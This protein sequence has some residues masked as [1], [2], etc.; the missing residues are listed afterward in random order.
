MNIG[1]EVT[2]GRLSNLNRFECFVDKYVE[3]ALMTGDQKIYQNKHSI[4]VILLI[5]IPINM[6]IK[7]VIMEILNIICDKQV[8]VTML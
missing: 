5:G 6:K 8:R 7:D 2:A 1:S 3:E 4:T